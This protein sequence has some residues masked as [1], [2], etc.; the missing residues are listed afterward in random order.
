MLVSEMKNI[1]VRLDGD[2][3]KKLKMI[4]DREYRPISNQI[5]LFVR[6]GIMRYAEEHNIDLD[7]AT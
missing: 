4:A 2:T 7:R 1:T 3:R 5:G 6:E